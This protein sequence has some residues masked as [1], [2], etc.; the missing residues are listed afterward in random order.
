L[1]V[2]ELAADQ[3]SE[4]GYGSGSTAASAPIGAVNDDGYSFPLSSLILYG[5]GAERGVSCGSQGE[6]GSQCYEAASATG[7]EP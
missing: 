3:P 7:A 2:E 4:G 6:H 1:S 5:S